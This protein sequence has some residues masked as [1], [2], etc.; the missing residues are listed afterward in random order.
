MSETV[1]SKINEI[2]K[3]FTEKITKSSNLS[4][5][6]TVIPLCKEIIAKIGLNTNTWPIIKTYDD[7][8]IYGECLYYFYTVNKPKTFPFDLLVLLMVYRPFIYHTIVLSTTYKDLSDLNKKILEKLSELY[9]NDIVTGKVNYLREL[10][11]LS[12]K[13]LE[14]IS[15]ITYFHYFIGFKFNKKYIGINKSEIDI[16]Q[17]ERNCGF[18]SVNVCN[19]YNQ[20][21]V[22]IYRNSTIN[23][24]NEFL[25]TKLVEKFKPIEKTIIPKDYPKSNI[26]LIGNVENNNTFAILNYNNNDF[27]I[28]CGEDSEPYKFTNVEMEN[29]IN[30][31][32]PN[33]ITLENYKLY[34]EQMYYRS[35]NNLIKTKEYEDEVN[36]IHLIVN[37]NDV[38]QI[39]NPI[40]DKYRK[41][42]MNKHVF[43]KMINSMKT[44]LEKNKKMD[45]NERKLFIFYASCY[46]YENFH[47]N[48]FIS[49]LNNY[50]NPGK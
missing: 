13:D 40:L 42:P 11:D 25:T 26:T 24:G 28:L 36:P 5:M 20:S 33:L 3:K 31:G 7:V 23:I 19:N 15:P 12:E 39:I 17:K 22:Y 50:F 32:L 38:F 1:I 37:A 48:E 30:G 8:D 34:A 29:F 6:E 27:T 9:G 41:A 46:P 45:I 47:T 10:I 14:N 43:D 18:I 4:Y 49:Y 44:E 35:L 2:Q 21:D 16:F